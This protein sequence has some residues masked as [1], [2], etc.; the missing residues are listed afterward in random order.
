MVSTATWGKGAK[1]A[2]IWSW[3]IW[4]VTEEEDDWASDALSITGGAVATA[5][6]LN[7]ALSFH[8]T[9]VATKAI[10]TNPVVQAITAA[11]VTGAIVSNEIDPE[12]G[13]DNYVGFI[14]GGTAEQH[15]GVGTAREDIHYFSGDPND[16]GYFN[17][18]R[19]VEIIA[20]HYYDTTV[21]GYK[22][23]GAQ[24][25]SGIKSTYKKT[26]AYFEEKKRQLL[27]RPSWI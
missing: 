13:F 12:S 14:T 22:K 19:N 27:Q 7:P 20:T 25:E 1:L 9:G 26:E 5:F 15:F 11:A 18:G 6:I 8:V 4:D 16:S 23:R 24:I 21:E 17:V 3:V 10:L 2:W